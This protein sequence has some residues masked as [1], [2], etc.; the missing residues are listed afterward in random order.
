M[1][2]C[3][4]G[5]NREDV[6]L[7]GRG[8]LLLCARCL[9][10]VLGDFRRGQREKELDARM[11]AGKAFEEAGLYCLREAMAGMIDILMDGPTARAASKVLREA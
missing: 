8:P 7:Y 5:C 11:R 10:M 3:C 2:E 6:E 9:D 4:S 1:R